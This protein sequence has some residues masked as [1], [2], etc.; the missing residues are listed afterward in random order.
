MIAPGQ[1]PNGDNLGMAFRSKKNG[2]LRLRIESPPY[3][4]F[5]GYT[6]DTCS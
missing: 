3:D 1:E 5:N 2:I 6:Q 4:D